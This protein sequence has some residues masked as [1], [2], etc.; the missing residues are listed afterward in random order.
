M[1]MDKRTAD[2]AQDELEF[3]RSLRDPASATTASANETIITIPKADLA[4]LVEA[5]RRARAF[6]NEQRDQMFETFSQSPSPSR[7]EPFDNMLA[8]IAAALAKVAT[9]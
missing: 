4:A 3:L 7:V 6:V 9:P 1:T 8:D 2:C 5:L